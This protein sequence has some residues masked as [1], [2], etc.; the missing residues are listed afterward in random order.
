MLVGMHDDLE[1]T[2]IKPIASRSGEPFIAQSLCVT[3]KAICLCTFL[4]VY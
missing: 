1:N 4:R 3:P 2:C